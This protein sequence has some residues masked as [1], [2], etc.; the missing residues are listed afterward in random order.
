MK[1]LQTGDLVFT[2]SPKLISRL[3]RL[4]SSPLRT[5]SGEYIPS[6]VGMIRVIC[7][8]PYI[9]EALWGN[10]F[11]KSQFDEWMKKHKG[12]Q[13]MVAR[14]PFTGRRVDLGRTLEEMEGI[15]YASLLELVRS[16]GDRNKDATSRDFCSAAVQ[17]VIER[18]L[19]TR[20]KSLEL[21]D[22][23]NPYELFVWACEIGFV[24][25]FF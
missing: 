22:N 12:E 1:P 25:P 13:V 14:M 21:P 10:G 16:I 18:S 2:K 23:T 6:H 8:E 5:I 17:R 7:G 4:F 9:Q 24:T 19:H 3:I 11:V 20:I 15:P